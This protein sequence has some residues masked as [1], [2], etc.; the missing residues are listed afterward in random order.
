MRA[1]YYDPGIGRFIS[2]DPIEGDL[3]NP[4]TQNGYNFTNGDPINYS[5]PS[6]EAVLPVIAACGV[7]A[8]RDGDCTNEARF[9]AS[10]VTNG[11]NLAK[12]LASQQQV[13]EV[14]K[15]IAGSNAKRTFDNA[16]ATAQ[17]YGGQA[18]EWVKK[19]SSSFTSPDGTQFETHW[20]ENIS[21]GE[22]VLQKTNL[23]K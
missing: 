10:N 19:T 3:L 17:Q 1:R 6:G 9:V 14:S 22:R 4:Q 7:A 8:C 23:I 5:D 11:I 20:V 21:T 15:I 13:N 12:S 18:I 2:R 16:V